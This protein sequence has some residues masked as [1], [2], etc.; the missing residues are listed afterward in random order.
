MSFG[1]CRDCTFCR[2]T[3]FLTFKD[4][5]D[6]QIDKTYFSD[7]E[8]IVKEEMP[9]TEF[10]KESWKCCRRAPANHQCLKRCTEGEAL[11]DSMF[12]KLNASDV[13][14]RTCGCGEFKPITY[15]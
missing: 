8:H 6:V 11:T 15:K 14:D 2:S 9:E 4:W 5:L 13:W 3:Y 1:F 7:D 12:P 10:L